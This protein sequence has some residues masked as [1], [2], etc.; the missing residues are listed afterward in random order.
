MECM[1]SSSHFILERFF[2]LWSVWHG[3]ATGIEMEIVFE[4][5]LM[6]LMANFFTLKRK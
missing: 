2:S 4:M 1:S 3:M 5:W 6:G